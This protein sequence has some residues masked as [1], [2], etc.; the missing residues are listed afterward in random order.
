MRALIP[1]LVQDFDEEGIAYCHWKGAAEL[2]RALRGERDLDLLVAPDDYARAVDVLLRNGWRQALRLMGRD[3]PGT[4]HFFGHDPA[5]DRLL[6]VHLHDRVLTGENLIN[7]HVLP[8]ESAILGDFVWHRG[9]K[10]ASPAAVAVMGVL[11]AAIRWGSLPDRLAGRLGRGPKP[12]TVGD[13]HELEAAAAWLH[14]H[15]ALVE[16]ET[17]RACAT[18]LGKG[19]AGRERR[20]LAR[21]VRR[22]LRPWARYGRLGRTAAYVG[23]VVTRVRRLAAGGGSERRLAT[24]GWVILIAFPG[25]PTA[26]LI[27]RWLGTAIALKSFRCDASPTGPSAGGATSFRWMSRTRRVMRRAARAADG[28][29]VAL[30]EVTPARVDHS[31]PGSEELSRVEMLLAGGIRQPDAVVDTEG[32]DI[33]AVRSVVWEALDHG[34]DGG[35]PPAVDRS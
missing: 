20:Y 28:G 3:D 34:V 23:W 19:A 16:E 12:V 33:G 8:L 13:G 31:L 24:G 18:V 4:A 1:R 21:R 14:D 17:F 7:S 25:A 26:D 2:E 10:T 30:T 11:K 29:V 22:A 9:I 35:S 15:G 5:V 27:R 32:M 6:H